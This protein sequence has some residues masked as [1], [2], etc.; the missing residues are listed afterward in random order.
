VIGEPGRPF[1]RIVWAVNPFR[2]DKFQAWGAP[3]AELALDF[4]ATAWAF[5]RSR[6]DPLTFEQY[7]AFPTK[8]DFERY[9]YSEQAAA[10]RVEATGLFQVPVLPE[11]FTM[12]ASGASVTLEELQRQ[13]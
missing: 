1:V 11:W 13:Q 3:F 12:V 4:G 7:A 6:E 9:W 10:M 5:V 8:T 2:G